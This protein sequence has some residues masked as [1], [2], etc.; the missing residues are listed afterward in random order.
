MSCISQEEMHDMNWEI[1]ASTGEW[2]GAIA[3]IITLIYLS[4]QI[5]LNARQFERQV[6]S[7]INSF[8]YRAYDPVYEGRN[9]EIMFIGLNDPEQLTGPDGFVFDLLMRRQ[10]GAMA[11][12]VELYTQGDLTKETLD[13]FADHYRR[14]YLSKRG[15]AKWFLE[16]ED[17]HQMLKRMGLLDELIAS[18]VAQ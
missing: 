12:A 7:D 3:V 6:V 1:I 15:G 13:G 2:V 10:A 14:V 9:A 5:R 8:I 11:S 18:G 4:R 16:N 17:S